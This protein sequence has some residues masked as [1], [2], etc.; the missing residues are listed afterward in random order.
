MRA[1]LLLGGIGVV[2]AGQGL[3][4]PD[5]DAAKAAKDVCPPC[6]LSCGLP[7]D[8]EVTRGE[9]E[10]MRAVADSLAVPMPPLLPGQKLV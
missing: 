2:S 8:G 6:A 3:V 5:Y 4:C 1:A 9:G 10:L 7:K